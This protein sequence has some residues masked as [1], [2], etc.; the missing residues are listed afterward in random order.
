MVGFA[1]GGLA[2]QLIQAGTTGRMLAL[3]AGRYD[4][5]PADTLLAATRHVDVGAMYDA[6]AY[7]AKLQR[8]AGMPMFLY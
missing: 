2:V 5:V 1:F 8:I 6:A 3:T 4:H 7:R